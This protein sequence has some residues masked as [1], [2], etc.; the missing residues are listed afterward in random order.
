MQKFALTLLLLSLFMVFSCGSQKE[1]LVLEE[2]TPESLLQ[3]AQVAM[4][5]GEF[6]QSI[7]LARTMINYYPTSDLHIDAQLLMAEAYGGK[8]EYE[9]Q[10]DLITRILRENIIPEKVPQIYLQLGTFYEHAARWNPGNISSDTTDIEKAAQYY[11]KAVFY[12]NSKDNVAKAEALYRAGLMYARLGDYETAAR[13]YEQVTAFYPETIHSQMAKLKA[14][15]PQDTSEIDPES[16]AEF[17]TVAA[18]TPEEVKPEAEQLPAEPANDQ[19][20]QQLIT[21]A[22]SDSLQLD[23]QINPAE[24]D[25]TVQENE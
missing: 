18:S 1:E 21:P 17:E 8:E 9:T 12:P 25:T 13:A 7:E 4:H 23:E 20:I 15:N 5:T 16:I 22:P 19:E 11:R 3:K 14:A 10:F 2:E 6:D 24:M